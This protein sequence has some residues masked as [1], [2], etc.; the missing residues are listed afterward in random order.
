MLRHG[1]LLNMSLYRLL[2]LPPILLL[3]FSNH[4]SSLSMYTYIIPLFLLTFCYLHIS[5]QILPFMCKYLRLYLLIVSMLEFFTMSFL[6]DQTISFCWNYYSFMVE[7]QIYN[8]SFIMLFF[9]VIVDFID[10]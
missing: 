3:D 10:I 8:W 4:I 2:S 1:L 7:L 6:L 5:Y 9:V